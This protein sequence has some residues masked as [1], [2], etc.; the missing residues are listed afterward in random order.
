MSQDGSMQTEKVGLAP[1]L[2]PTAAWALAL[3]ASVGWGSLVV[4]AN[5]Y[6]VQA[7]PLGSTLGILIGGAIMLVIARNY[8]YMMNCCPDAGGAYAYARTTFGYDHGFLTAW[9]LLLTYLAILW[10]NATSLPLFAR[11]FVG[12]ELQFIYLYT[13]FGYDVY[14]GEALLSLGAI[15]LVALLCTRFK[16]A[17][18]VVL[19]ALAGV[20]FCGITACFLVAFFGIDLPIEPLFVPNGNEFSQ[21][22]LIAC[23]SPWAFIGFESISHA[24]EEFTFPQ[25]K[26][27]SVLAIA[28]VTTTA[29]YIFVTLLSV[30]AFP[31]EYHSW[32]EY[33]SD[34]G[35]LSGIEALPPFYAASHYLGDAG[36]TILMASLLAL[37]GTSLIGT[38]LALSR[39]LFS[40][41]R[42]RVLPGALADLNVQR[43]PWKA[44]LAVA[45]AS[46]VIPFLGRV[47]VGWIVDVTTFG[48]TIVYG[49]VSACTW[50]TASFRN[51]V[52]EKRTGLIGVVIMV[53]FC[54]YLLVPNLF[55]S[56]SM[57]A[58]SHFLFV[59]WAVLG[60]IMFRAVLSHD[61]QKRFGGS[62]IVWVGLLSLVLF[63]SLVWMSESN[64]DATSEAMNNIQQHYSSA[65]VELEE[66]HY[67]M[68]QLESIRQANSRSIIVVVSLFALSLGVL[69][70]NYSTL[71]RRARRSEEELGAV[72]QLAS[73]DPLTGVKSKHAYVT[74]EATIDGQIEAGTLTEL[75]VAVCDVNGLKHV[76]DTFGHQAGDEYIRSASRLICQ[77]FQHSPVF[78][79]GG[80]EF[81]VILTGND[82]DNRIA[83]MEQLNYQVESNIGTDEVVIAAGLAE[84]LPGEE[85]SLRMV[86]ER[87]DGLMY[88]RK[89]ELKAMGARTR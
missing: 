73:T 77:V 11:I 78:R 34:I 13:L 15:V 28:V 16:K 64:M 80:D 17:I 37:V 32:L 58:E 46:L 44:V 75:A 35:N 4:T 55:T 65:S 88:K 8:H 18:A 47:T 19:I 31:P 57:E 1:Y 29:L 85:T 84:L 38:I 89:Q 68:E 14:L 83:L 71:S 2:S 7:G 3:G 70:N 40:L 72:R 67:M 56:G 74:R 59:V 87:A 41:G 6:L 63:V 50:K 25:K 79:I 54:L 21:A 22:V 30:T 45:A 10:A 12:D 48:A 24:S 9:F 81:V 62:I 52:I 33:V 36:V 53:A 23:I 51:D 61:D 86:F 26:A 5:T 27:F 20:F 42:D 66:D 82:Y 49:F 69:L 39:L 76:N 60:F 43:I